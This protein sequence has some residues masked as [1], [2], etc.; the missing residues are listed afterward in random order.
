[1]KKIILLLDSDIGAWVVYNPNLENERGRI[2][3]FNNERQ[4]AWVVYKANNNWDGDHWKDYTAVAT[5]YSD[6]FRE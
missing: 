5:N 4:V 2:K 6:I 1:M 3:S